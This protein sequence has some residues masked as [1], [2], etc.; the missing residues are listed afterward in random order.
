MSRIYGSVRSRAG[1]EIGKLV[2]AQLRYS[3]SNAEGLAQA[4]IGLLGARKSDKKQR[5]TSIA[6]CPRSS[7]PKHQRDPSVAFYFDRSE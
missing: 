2:A 3:L 6:H 4:D 1:E 7:R 5:C